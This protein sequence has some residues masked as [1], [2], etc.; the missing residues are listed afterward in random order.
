[1]VISCK[2]ISSLVNS[3]FEER[4]LC[5]G[6][7][8]CTEELSF[9]AIL[10]LDGWVYHGLE[11]AGE[12]FIV[13]ILMCLLRYKWE[14]ERERERESLESSILDRLIVCENVHILNNIHVYSIEVDLIY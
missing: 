9:V 3:L 12:M 6:N 11:H 1:M 13:V 7:W 8:D 2:Y 14:R 4:Q 10:Q 5:I